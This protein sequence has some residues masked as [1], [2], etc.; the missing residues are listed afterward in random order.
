MIFRQVVNDKVLEVRSAGRTRRLYVDGVLHTQHNPAMPL[1]GD[2]WDPIALSSLLRAPEG[3]RRVLLLGVGGGAAIHLLRR[4]VEPSLIVGVELDGLRID[5]ARRFFGLPRR[6]SNLRLH[7]A[8][9]IEWLRN[10]SG[11]PFDMI[12]DDLFGQEEGQ[13][14]R[15]IEL[16]RPWLGTLLHALAPDGLLTVNLPD[17][18]TSTRAMQLLRRPLRRRFEA[19]F[20]FS[21]PHAENAITTFGPATSSR[22][23]LR[24]R[25]ATHPSMA[26]QRAK[27]LA[28]FRIYRIW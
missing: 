2:V 23:A 7:Q 25:L 14:V 26:T 27:A 11:P 22:R 4:F 28:R 21:S 17:R 12:I 18:E 24:R 1:T 13:P 16:E 20:R 15:A 6:A 9:A 8:D 10:Y 5:L 3:T 19:A